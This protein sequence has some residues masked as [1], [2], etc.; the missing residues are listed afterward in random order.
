M[1]VKNLM[2]K[3]EAQALDKRADGE[4]SLLDSPGIMEEENP[5][6]LINIA[7][8]GLPDLIESLPQGYLERSEREL[9]KVVPE[10]PVLN[11]L[12]IAFWK[13]YDAAQGQMRNML[14]TNIAQ[15]MQRPS[16]M[17]AV[18][19]HNPQTLSYILCP[20]TNYNVFLEEAHAFSLDKI[21]RILDLPL[22]DEDG[23][24]NVKLGELQLKAAAFIDLRVQGGFLQKSVHAEL[25][26]GTDQV[27]KL[28]KDLSSDELDKKIK[29]LEQRKAQQGVI[30]VEP[31]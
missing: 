7:P 28:A 12:R 14:W 3:E 23:K 31:S 9:R 29:E 8:K 25:G 11:Q 18:Y 6:S 15:M 1:D 13:E 21:R 5:R 16:A 17:I 19:F 27:K 10:D 30:D 20:P 2:V 22:V 4:H 24:V 26:M